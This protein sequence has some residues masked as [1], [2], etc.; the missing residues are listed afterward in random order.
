MTINNKFPI[1]RKVQSRTRFRWTFSL[2]L[3]YTF[4]ACTI[5]VFNCVDSYNKGPVQQIQQRISDIPP[6][7]VTSST[8]YLHFE[9]GYI[10]STQCTLNLFMKYC[11]GVTRIRL[12]LQPKVYFLRDSLSK[13][14]YCPD[15][16]WNDNYTTYVFF[17]LK[18]STM[19]YFN[20][21]GSW[22]DVSNPPWIM[23]G[24]FTTKPD[25][26]ADTSL[27]TAP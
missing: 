7:A 9:S 12:G 26:S 20:I 11:N 22:G 5:P 1:P 4:L 8:P 27:T 16:S 10:G 24:H 17:N 2:F 13:P 23:D 3:F 6:D 18:P 19:Y 25:S 21:Y 14:P 15:S